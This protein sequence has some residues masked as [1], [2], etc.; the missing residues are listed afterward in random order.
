M[1][2][3]IIPPEQLERFR[4]RFDAERQAQGKPEYIESEAVYN[5]LDGLL[6]GT[7]TQK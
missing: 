5:L 4:A 7:K 1:S 6:I 2:V 3:T